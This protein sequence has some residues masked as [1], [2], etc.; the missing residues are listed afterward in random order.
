MAEKLAKALGTKG[1]VV[2]YHM[3]TERG[4]LEH[5]AAACPKWDKQLRAIA[6]RLVD[7]L[8]IIRK[9]V[10]DIGFGGSFS[11][12][13]VGPTLLGKKFSYEGLDVGG[14]QQAQLAYEEMISPKTTAKRKAEIRISLIEYCGQ[15]TLAMVKLVEWLYKQASK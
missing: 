6:E 7:P 12:K 15:D 8:P 10:Y 13:S 2:S 9:S 11:I 14:G 5:I 4:C 3:S 1:S